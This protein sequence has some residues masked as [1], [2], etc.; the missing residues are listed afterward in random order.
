[1]WGIKVTD[2]FTSAGSTENRDASLMVIDSAV[3][4]R[5]K[6]QRETQRI[7]ENH[8]DPLFDPDE[9]PYFSPLGAVI[10]FLTTRGDEGSVDSRVC[11]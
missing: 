4:M 1:M 2:E 7:V 5:P 9:W 8:E 11:Q 10:S 6:K 3:A